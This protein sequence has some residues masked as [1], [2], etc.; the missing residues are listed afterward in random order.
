MGLVVLERANSPLLILCLVLRGNW[1]CS[2][3]CWFCLNAASDAVQDISERFA[4]SGHP[5]EMQGST[6]AEH[7]HW[8]LQFTLICTWSCIFFLSPFHPGL[9]LMAWGLKGATV[10]S[11][12]SLRLEIHPLFGLCVSVPALLL[13]T[14]EQSWPKM[15]ATLKTDVFITWSKGSTLLPEV[16]NMC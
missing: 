15:L 4:R 12:I 8:G 10:T 13:K 6:F 9:V 16:P 5:A 7:L 3:C 1:N 14:Q 2:R 11:M